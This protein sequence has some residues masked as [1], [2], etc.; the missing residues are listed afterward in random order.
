MKPDRDR[1]GASRVLASVGRTRPRQRTSDRVYEELASAI[2]DLRI[3]PGASLSETELAEQL[4]VS[5][6][7]L[8][9][10]IVRLVETGLVSVVPQVGTRVELIRLDDVE[11]AR[12]VRESLE[13]AAFA[14]ACAK[15]VRDVSALRD[16]LA[17]QERCHARGDI[18]AFF[19]AD[20]ALHEQIFAISGYLGAWQVMQPMKMHLD[21]LRRLSLPEPHT[22]Q[23][24]IAEHTAI[25]D[26][27]EAGDAAGGR[28]HLV[29]HA[30]R[31]QNTA[32]ALQAQY[33]EYFS[34]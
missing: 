12:F 18:D 4:H 10:A 11:Q 29:R 33:P 5:R 15:P 8:R 6:T 34:S 23:A 21:R 20:E 7:P 30:R 27:L 13:T 14:E 1:P 22:V 31:V 9:E 3:P 25:V 2:R 26:A 32:P 28:E 24:L 19:A 16:L 17:E